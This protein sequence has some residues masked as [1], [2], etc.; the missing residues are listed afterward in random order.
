MSY[1]RIYADASRFSISRVGYEVRT[2]PRTPDYMAVDSS[3]PQVTRLLHSGILFN[4]TYD[5][6]N[7]VFYGT[8]YATPP[9]VEIYPYNYGLSR[10]EQQINFELNTDGQRTYGTDFAINQRVDRFTFN[11]VLLLPSGGY[12]RVPRDF[13]YFVY[14]P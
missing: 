5:A 8:T 4:L 1:G 7:T 9:F 12:A 11:G 2:A 14:P 10:S 3:F 13:I 6:I